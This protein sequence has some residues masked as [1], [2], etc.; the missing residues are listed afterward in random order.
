MIDLRN[1]AWLARIEARRSDVEHADVPGFVPDSNDV[2]GPTRIVAQRDPLAVVAPEGTYFLTGDAKGALAFGRDGR[3]SVTDGWLCGPDG[4]RV[5]GFP[6]G[7]GALA[8]LRIDPRDAALGGIGEPRIE[9]DG[10]FVYGRMAVDPRSGERRVERATVGRIALARFP[11][12]TQ[13]ART[14]SAHVSPPPGV[15]PRVGCPAAD[16]FPALV[17]QARDLGRVD[18]MAGLARL[19]EAYLSYGALRA[20]FRGRAEVEKATLELVK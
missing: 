7:A 17:T 12:G 14:G 10:S 20:A 15:A 6:H 3:F 1:E 8:P 5:L 16:G 4:R 13:P 19:D 2:A 11:A 18:L 9:P